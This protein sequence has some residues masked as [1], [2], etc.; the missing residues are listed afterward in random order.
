[1][2]RRI[3]PV[4]QSS[5]P[6]PPINY[7]EFI[8]LYVDDEAANLT[9]FRYSFDDE[10]RVLTAGGAEE[11]LKILSTES[12]AV[13]LSDQRMPGTTG[14]ELCACVRERYP[15]V[16][17]MV[18]SAY[19]D[20]AAALDAINRG[21]V[22]R[23]I[24]KPWREDDMA[25]V[26]RTAIEAFHVGRLM[27]SLQ[28][29]LL[30]SEQQAGAQ[31]AFSKV[32]HELSNPMGALRT[33]IQYGV[34]VLG[35]K[36]TPA[37]EASGLDEARH[38]L[39]D[40]LEGANAIKA[41]I[42]LFRASGAP[43]QSTGKSTHL[44]RAVASAVA[45]VRGELRTRA[46]LHVDEVPVP[47]VAIDPVQAS[48]VLVNLLL[49]AY[50]ALPEGAAVSNRITVRVRPSGTGALVEVEDT[51]R[52]IPADLIG[53]IFT[54][55]VTLKEDQANHGLGLAIVREII[56]AAGGSI[57]VRSQQGRGTTFFFE[58]PGAAEPPTDTGAK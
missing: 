9:A 31:A 1:M 23:Y 34:D 43:T 21:Q 32:L 47:A 44:G 3:K 8:V 20:L 25:G 5:M 35:L 56:E 58:L 50:E 57:S 17:R 26:L 33:N 45:I 38:A 18:V 19:S 10:F 22:T 28:T 12:V 52:G 55:F 16:V 48:Q 4:E 42:E 24:L 41:R 14:A 15:D 29:R 37:P 11:A 2:W 40:A 53:Q 6:L 13:L 46:Q 54:P 49:N 30:Q 27:R 7:R 36:G 39:A 51:G